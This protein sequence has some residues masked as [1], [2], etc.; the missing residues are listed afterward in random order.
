MVVFTKGP[1]GTGKGFKVENLFPKGTQVTN[2]DRPA[3]APP[4]LARG[5]KVSRI[6]SLTGCLAHAY[7]PS[8]QDSEARGSLELRSQKARLHNLRPHLRVSMWLAP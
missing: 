3:L 5:G 2:T 4:N 6:N 8:F 1:A 7:V